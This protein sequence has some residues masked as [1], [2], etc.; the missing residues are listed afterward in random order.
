MPRCCKGY[1]L[2]SVADIVVLLINLMG[3]RA[4][5]DP[6][7]LGRL[8]RFAPAGG[9]IYPPAGAWADGV[10]SKACANSRAEK[11]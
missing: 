4:R 3:H 11:V 8:S 1:P 2:V 7:H 5:M 10:P 6:P 9:Q